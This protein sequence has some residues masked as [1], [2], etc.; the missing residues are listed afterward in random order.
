MVVV[1]VTSKTWDSK[2]LRSTGL[3]VVDFWHEACHWCSRLEPILNELAQECQDVQ[4]VRLNV[5]TN[6]DH[7]RLANQYRIMG[8]PTLVFFC[9][10]RPVGEVVGYRPKDGLRKQVEESLSRCNTQACA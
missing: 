6:E 7:W 8:S 1:D 3:V 9:R 2:V 10:G 5:L 4:F